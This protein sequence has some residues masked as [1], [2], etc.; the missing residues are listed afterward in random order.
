MKKPTASSCRDA[1]S[2]TSAASHHA[3]VASVARRRRRSR[4]RA[5][6]VR[7]R[8]GAGGGP[9]SKRGLVQGTTAAPLSPR[10]AI[11]RCVDSVPCVGGVSVKVVS[12][13][14]TA[15]GRGSAPPPGRHR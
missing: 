3:E 13:T 6:A 11:A 5:L 2:R 4:R 12:F 8:L 7:R 1:S 9:T 14:R 10:V 15:R